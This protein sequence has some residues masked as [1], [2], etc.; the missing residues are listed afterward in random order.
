M[1]KNQWENLGED[2]LNSVFEAADTGDFSNLSRNV[3]N[4]VNVTF[5]KVGSAVRDGIQQA[6]TQTQS[7]YEKQKQAGAEYY[8]KWQEQQKRQQ[9]NWQQPMGN[10][11]QLNAGQQ[12]AS[13]RRNTN[14]N[15]N[16]QYPVLY[17]KNVPGK[18]AG[19]LL[20]V[21]GGIGIGVFGLGTIGFGIAGLV[22]ASLGLLITSGVFAAITAG[23]IVM[24][25]SGNK[26]SRRNKRFR[27][28]VR[29]LGTKSYCKIEDMATQVGKPLKFVKKDLKKMLSMGYFL[30]GHIDHDE[31]TM[32]ASNEVYEQ[33]TQAER[34][35]IQREEEEKTPKSEV[36]QLVAEGQRYIAHIHECNDAIPGE[37]ISAKL[38]RLEDIM[39]R[40]FEQLKH[41]PESAGDL[42]KLMNYY[43]PTTTKLIDTYRELDAKPEVGDNI[44][45]TKKEIEDTLDTINFAFE[46]IF[47]D[48]FLDTA[49]DISSDISVMKTMMAQEGLTQQ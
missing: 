46:K 48:M 30:Q 23:F 10:Q 43:L 1:G 26:I 11:Q 27:Q 20:T 9:Q 25:G 15:Q 7:T 39:T 17:R 32:I 3:E 5:D 29:C 21:F 44:K 47:D 28:Y 37:E 8:K 34:A 19:P 6:K 40:I 4:L 41:S 42:R 33:Y 31:T 2:I 13:L 16:N 45:K 35:R 24:T 38:Q 12:G 22:T 14:Q 18:Y 49:W 36:E